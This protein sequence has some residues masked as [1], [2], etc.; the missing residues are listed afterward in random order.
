MLKALESLSVG[1]DHE[2]YAT[3]MQKTREKSLLRPTKFEDTVK[4][5][6]LGKLLCARLTCYRR[7]RGNAFVFFC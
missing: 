2:K 1:V 7:T 5:F 6:W 3:Y 4:D